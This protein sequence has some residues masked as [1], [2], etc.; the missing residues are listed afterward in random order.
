M[1]LKQYK[2]SKDQRIFFFISSCMQWL[3]IWLSGFEN[4]HWLLYVPPILFLGASLNGFCSMMIITKML[5]GK[6]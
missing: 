3:G 4:V 5:F 6:K 2:L 1:N